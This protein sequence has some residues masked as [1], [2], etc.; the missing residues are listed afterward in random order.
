L[1]LEAH[2]AFGAG[3]AAAVEAMRR[4]RECLD[5]VR[6]SNN[7]YSRRMYRLNLTLT[8]LNIILLS[9]M[10]MPQILLK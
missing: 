9:L 6:L 5:A 3:G 1:T 7:R 10:G 8:I 2:A 4:L